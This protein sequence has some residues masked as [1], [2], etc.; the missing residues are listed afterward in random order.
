VSGLQIARLDPAAFD[1]TIDE[2]AALLLDAVDGG[3]SV[4]FVRPFTLEAAAAWWRGLRADVAA[5]RLIVLAARADGRAVGT[6]Q[7]RLAQLPNA[8]HRAEVAKLLVHGT[9][10]RRGIGRA[11]MAAIEEVAR[12]EARTLLVL[13]TE[14]GS[15]AE[16]LYQSLGWTRAGVI[17]GYAVHSSDD[18]CPTTIFY[19]EVS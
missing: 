13:D 14:T 7:L 12:G 19:K 11:L 18:T 2:L 10:R 5:G 6:V 8:R 17:P 3:A 15:D 16:R 9:A 4:G 1:R